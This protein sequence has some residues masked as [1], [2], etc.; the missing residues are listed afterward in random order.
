VSG[1]A[2][3][4]EGDS[5]LQNKRP[6]NLALVKNFDYQRWKIAVIS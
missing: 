6:Y 5:V 1:V 4:N 3:I 2:K